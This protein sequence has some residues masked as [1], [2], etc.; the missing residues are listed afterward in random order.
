MVGSGLSI[1]SGHMVPVAGHICSKEVLTNK[2]SCPHGG[3]RKTLSLEGL[4]LIFLSPH[5]T[6]SKQNS[7]VCG[8]WGATGGQ[9]IDQPRRREK[10]EKH[11]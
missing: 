8:L 9:H 5:L 2:S 4:W 10:K 11:L 1:L 6:V 3:L 7:P